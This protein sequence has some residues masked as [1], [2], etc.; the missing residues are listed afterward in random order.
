MGGKAYNPSYRTDWKA[1]SRSASLHLIT[2]RNRSEFVTNGPDSA[3]RDE[4]GA[5]L[6]EPVAFTTAPAVAAMRRSREGESRLTDGRASGSRTACTT[7]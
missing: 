5:M 3:I 2:H 7:N 1:R 4:H 6:R